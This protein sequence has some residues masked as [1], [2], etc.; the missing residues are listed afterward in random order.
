[1]GNYSKDCP[2]PK[3]NNGGSKIN[4]LTTN[5]AQG[6]CNCLIFLKGKVSKRDV[7]CLFGHMG[8]PQLHNSKKCQKDG[9]PVGRAQGSPS[10]HIV[11]KI[12]ASSTRELEGKGGFVG[13]H[14]IGDGLHSRNEIHHP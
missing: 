14:L 8:F 11:S 1:M 9:A 12:C 10:H 7:L 3:L 13:F 4:T 6:E 2:K 5:L